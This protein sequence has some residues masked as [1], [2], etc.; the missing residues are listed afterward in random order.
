MCRI[1]RSHTSVKHTAS[2]LAATITP[3]RDITQG[4]ELHC[5]ALTCFPTPLDFQCSPFLNNLHHLPFTSQ[6][7]FANAHCLLCQKISKKL[8]SSS[9]LK[10]GGKGHSTLKTRKIKN[11]HSILYFE[12]SLDV[13]NGISLTIQ[14][15]EERSKGKE[16]Y[17]LLNED[18][19]RITR[20]DKNAFLS[21]QCKEIED[22]N[23]M[24]KT[25]DL[26]KKIRH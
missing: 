17:K 4:F 16:G 10:P 6:I 15:A 11:S 13:S 19:Q 23:R 24:R 8:A 26:Q 18:F 20:R 14:L 25:R 22:T 2:D 3:L 7:T 5:H 9:S 21:E 12:A 1:S